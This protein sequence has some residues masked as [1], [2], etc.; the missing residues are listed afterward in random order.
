VYQPPVR[1]YL[2]H[3]LVQAPGLPGRRT[4]YHQQEAAVA[5]KYPQHG[6][7]PDAVIQIYIPLDIRREEVQWFAWYLNRAVHAQ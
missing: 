4:A 1:Q 6:P 5:A 7:Q 3:S 2:P